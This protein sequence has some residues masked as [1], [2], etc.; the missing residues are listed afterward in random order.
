MLKYK[1]FFE[2]DIVTTECDSDGTYTAYINQST[3]N[4]FNILNIFQEIAEKEKVERDDV[5]LINMA[6]VV[7]N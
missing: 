2:Y 7:E 1:W 4:V 5:R 6:R 3:L